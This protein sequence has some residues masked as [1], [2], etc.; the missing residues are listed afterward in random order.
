MRITLAWPQAGLGD[1]DDTVDVDEA[2]GVRLLND[3]LAR[4]PDPVFADTE[5]A[6]I[7]ANDLNEAAAA[8]GVDLGDATTVGQKRAAIAAARKQRS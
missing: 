3:G 1:A 4:R 6:E 2:T 5:P 8:E 7:D